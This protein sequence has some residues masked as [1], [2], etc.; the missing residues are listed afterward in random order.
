MISGVPF[1]SYQLFL[2]NFSLISICGFIA[3]RVLA[4]YFSK[5]IIVETDPLIVP[6]SGR[7]GHRTQL[8]VL[9]PI[10]LRIMRTFFPNFD[11]HA[12]NVGITIRAAWNR[13]YV[14]S[15]KIIWSPEKAPEGMI[16]SRLTCVLIV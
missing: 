13:W 11:E 4:D 6:N 8:H 9:L 3:A 10:T 16:A 12:K 2:L 1:Q 7:V 15:Y 5:V 14:G